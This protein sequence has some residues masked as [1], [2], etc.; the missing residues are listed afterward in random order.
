[1]ALTFLGQSLFVGIGRIDPQSVVLG[2]AAI[3]TVVMAA[4]YWPSK[5]ATRIDPLIVFRDS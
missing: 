3:V 4:S 5:K 1:M 2:V